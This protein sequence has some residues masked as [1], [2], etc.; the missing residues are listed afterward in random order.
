MY[1]VRYSIIYFAKL[2]ER[3]RERETKREREAFYELRRLNVIL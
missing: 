2:G 1:E 3:E